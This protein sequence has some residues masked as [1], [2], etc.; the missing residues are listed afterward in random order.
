MPR[1]PEAETFGLSGPPLHDACAGQT[2]S[3]CGGG[4]SVAR[5]EPYGA[6]LYNRKPAMTVKMSHHEAEE[7]LGFKPPYPEDLTAPEVCHIALTKACN[8]QCSY[9]YLRRSEPGD[10]LIQS[11]VCR[12]L[13]ELADA[14]VLQVTF[15]GGEPCVRDDLLDLAEHATSRGLTVS[16]TTNGDFLH[17][18][19]IHRFR[20]FSQI[21]ISVHDSCADEAA[22]DRLTQRIAYLKS[23]TAV[24]LNVVAQPWLL[25]EAELLGAL[26]AKHSLTITLL[27]AKGG[28]G[29]TVL[30]PD[31]ADVAT[32][33][34][35]LLAA[36]ASVRLECSI[37][38]RCPAGMRF[39]NIRSDGEVTPCVFLRG[40][41]GN[42]RSDSFQSIWQAMKH[43]RPATAVRSLENT[44]PKG[45]LLCVSK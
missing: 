10:E 39:I 8:R 37:A 17:K 19:P 30:R 6:L 3:P 32:A 28:H 27:E 21:N 12:I 41:Y 24:G 40:S 31:R 33:Y 7:L 20:A 34:R 23:A 18:F 36:G 11:Q 44:R 22:C 1:Q 4:E 16:M 5:K 14:G 9:C 43:L 35:R 38:G 45:D 26:A 2:K 42:L 15:G 13:D 29:E 25:A